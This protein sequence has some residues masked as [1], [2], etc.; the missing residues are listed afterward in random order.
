MDKQTYKISEQFMTVLVALLVK[1]L[2]EQTDIVPLLQDLNITE[3][4]GELVVQNPPTK[5]EPKWDSDIDT[6]SGEEV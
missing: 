5:I 4:D 6:D 3:E 2:A 1:C